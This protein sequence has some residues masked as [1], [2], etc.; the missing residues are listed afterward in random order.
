MA[1]RI[2]RFH[3]LPKMCAQF[4]HVQF[5]DGA[6]NFGHIQDD[7][8]FGPLL[9]LFPCLIEQVVEVLKTVWARS[10]YRQIGIS[11]LNSKLPDSSLILD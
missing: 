4:V 7:H 11:F 2:A 9:T 6:G 5:G 10:S 1:M 3:T 8:I